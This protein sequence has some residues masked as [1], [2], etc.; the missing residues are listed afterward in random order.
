[1]RARGG[2]ASRSRY[3]TLASTRGRRDRAHPSPPPTVSVEPFQLTQT[4][5]APSAR[6]T[7][8]AG[9]SAGRPLHLARNPRYDVPP[10]RKRPSKRTLPSAE[11]SHQGRR[12]SSRHGLRLRRLAAEDCQDKPIVVFKRDN[13]RTCHGLLPSRR[14]QTNPST[15][16]P[17]AGH[18]SAYVLGLDMTAENALP[19]DDTLESSVPGKSGPPQ[20]ARPVGGG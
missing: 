16:I 2:C 6:C 4:E 11:N 19:Q 9:G 13:R 17:D 3:A 14:V 8:T 7:A 10:P 15:R 1:M 18:S 20:F 5:V 12:S